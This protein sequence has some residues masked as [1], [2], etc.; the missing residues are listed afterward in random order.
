MSDN[1][2][3]KWVHDQMDDKPDSDWSSIDSA[4]KDGSCILL[5][6]GSVGAYCDYEDKFPAPMVVGWWVSEG[7][8]PLIDRE[9][10]Y[11][12]S[13]DGGYYGRYYEPK[14]WRRLP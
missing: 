9:G 4:P 7:D 6:G 13:Y 14:E 10:W 3:P 1:R 12:S 2:R 8:E 5:R 11:F